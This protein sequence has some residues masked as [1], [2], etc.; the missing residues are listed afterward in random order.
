MRTGDPDGRGRPPRP[1]HPRRG[2]RPRGRPVGHRPRNAAQPGHP[3]RGRR[4]P[5]ARHHHR[6]GPQD[7]RAR[8]R[9]PCAQADERDLEVRV[10]FLHGGARPPAHQVVAYIDVHRQ[11]FGVEPIC[12]VLQVAPS[13]YYA[14]KNR[15]PSLRSRT[16]GDHPV[17]RHRS[18]HPTSQVTN[19]I[20]GDREIPRIQG[21][22]QV[23]IK[24]PP[25]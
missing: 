14:A 1:G 20:D 23:V 8:T 24:R 10:G 5:P 2:H 11:E 13:T 25:V 18:N 3:G 22:H 21:V 7:R 12:E 4:R 17:P 6:P 16:T 9:E 15:A 19:R